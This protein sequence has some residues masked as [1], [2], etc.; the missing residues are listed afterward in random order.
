MAPVTPSWSR[1]PGPPHALDPP[2]ICPCEVCSS[3]PP[4]PPAASRRLSSATSRFNSF[5]FFP[6]LLPPSQ[7]RPSSAQAPPIPLSCAINPLHFPPSLPPFPS[8][9][10]SPRPSL[11]PTP[12]PC[13]LSVPHLHL[14][15]W[16]L[17]SWVAMEHC[18]PWIWCATPALGVTAVHTLTQKQCVAHVC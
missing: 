3:P 18:T 10:P 1:F 14:L 16:L 4:P 15:T 12:L 7:S 6:V 17:T 5:L 2:C 13:Q 9:S 8:R 11:G